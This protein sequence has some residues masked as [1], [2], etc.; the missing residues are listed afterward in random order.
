MQEAVTLHLRPAAT[1]TKGLFKKSCALVRKIFAVLLLFVGCLRPA[2]GMQPCPTEN[3]RLSKAEIVVEARVKSLL[4]GESGLLDENGTPTR[5]V[6]ADL[7]IKRVIKGKF[8]GKE[9]TVYEAAYDSVLGPLR[10]LA[11]MASVYGLGDEDS[12]EVELSRKEFGDFG[13]TMFSLGSCGYWKFPDFADLRP[14]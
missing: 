13:V 1:A 11:V 2:V 4:I 3:E 9:A 10:P 14:E 6:R 8:A 7:E 5:M 12:F